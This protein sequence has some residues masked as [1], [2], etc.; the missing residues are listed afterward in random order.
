M[1]DEQVKRI[2]GKGNEIGG[3]AFRPTLWIRMLYRDLGL[4]VVFTSESGG[5]LR[6]ARVIFQPLRD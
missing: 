4:M 5:S 2:L 6:V 1:T 3:S